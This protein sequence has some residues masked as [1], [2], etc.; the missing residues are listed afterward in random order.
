MR[1][2]RKHIAWYLSGFPHAATFRK[3]ACE[4]T[5][6]AQVEQIADTVRHLTDGGHV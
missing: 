4:I 6:Y 1:E 3:Q 5:N 2:M